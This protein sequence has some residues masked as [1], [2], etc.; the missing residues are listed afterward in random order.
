[1]SSNDLRDRRLFPRLS[2]ENET[3]IFL[4][5]KNPGAGIR[6]EYYIRGKLVD[7]SR[8]G[9]LVKCSATLAFLMSLQETNL[10]ILNLFETGMDQT[11]VRLV[12]VSKEMKRNFFQLAFEMETPSG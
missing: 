2:P 8:K 3:E 5:R 10:R 7:I 9:F 11:Q 1:M 6:Q 4:W 12:R